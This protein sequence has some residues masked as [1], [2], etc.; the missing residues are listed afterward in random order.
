MKNLFKHLVFCL[1]LCLPPLGL[2]AQEKT[3]AYYNSH[4]SEILPDAQA[5]FRKGDYKRT[6]ELCRW[7]YIIFGDNTASALRDKADRCSKL[8]DEMI[9]LKDAGQVKEAKQKASALL[10]LNPDDS[11]AKA[12]LSIE[13]VVPPAQV[14]DAVVVTPPVETI[15]IPVKAEIPQDESKKDEITEN[16]QTSVEEQPSGAQ[17]NESNHDAT[18]PEKTYE[19]RTRFVLKAGASILDLGQIPQTLAPGAAIG[20]YD[21]G[22]SRIGI[23]AGGFFCPGLSGL[24]TSLMGLDAGLVIRGAKGIYPKLGVGLFSCKSIEQNGTATKGLCAGGGITFLLGGHFCIEL[25]AKYYPAVKVSD[26]ETVSTAGVSYEF[27]ASREVLAGGIA[28]EIRI[29]WAF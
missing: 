3:L 28:P 19:P 9:Q 8:T 29:G 2:F 12:T 1:L 10:I 18:L 15:N 7:H 24:S 16:I 20:L 6:L 25:G 14:E 4:E 17:V 21:L 27:P 11:A 22:G 26:S 5:A 23:E 13:E